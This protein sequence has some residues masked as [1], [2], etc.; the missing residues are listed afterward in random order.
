MPLRFA[1]PIAL[2]LLLA[3][4]AASAAAPNLLANPGFDTGLDGWQTIGGSNVSWDGT[5]DAGGSPS[6]GSAK[7]DWQSPAVTGLQGVV[8]QCVEVTTGTTYQFGG[9][10]F[11]PSGQ[12]T[13]GSAFFIA[14]FYPTHGCSGP[15]PPAA[16]VQ[17]PP[18]LT[19]GAWTESIGTVTAFGPSVLVSAY[20]APSTGGRLQANFDDALLQAQSCTSDSLTLC[21]KDGRF[22]ITAS[23]DAGGGNSGQAKMEPAGDGGLLWFFN[24]A[25]IEAVVKVIDG[26]ALGGHFWFFAG[27]LTNVQVTI[28]VTDTHTGVTKTYSN[29][30]G[31][32]FAP[33]QDTSAF[34]CG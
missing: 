28:T 4:P 21:P 20:L 10:I 12:A 23:F 2:A 19:T 31:T 7:I 9:K 18:I 24:A 15:P 8:S 33:I 1:V 6:S 5:K 3:G 34:D 25:N 26:C 14:L 29:P 22:K 13:A 11:I 30:R 16:F 27:G 32:A 17:S